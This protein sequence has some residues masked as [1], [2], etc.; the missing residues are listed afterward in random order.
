[1]KAK[2]S[3]LLG[4][5]LATLFASLPA[6]AQTAKNKDVKMSSLSGP[7]IGV[8]GGYGWND[9]DG[10]SDPD[11]WDGGVFAGYRLGAIV[12]ETS[13]FGIGAN[14]AIEAFYGAS[15]GEEG[16]TEKEDEWGI[17]F[18]PGL[19]VIDRVTSPLG[20]NPYGILGYRNTEF[21]TAGNSE[22]Y[23]G[24]EL[25]IGTQLVA[26]GDVGLRLEYAHTWFGEKAGIDPSTNDLR[27][28]VSYHF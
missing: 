18:R 22:R 11:G 27:L 14:G 24:F 25:G 6:I 28:G 13:D 2:N 10:G 12:D 17:S 20:L 7:Y 9:L 8:Y 15:N 1:M 26:Y 4:V 19:S 5:A 23:N 16:T 3:L 21:T